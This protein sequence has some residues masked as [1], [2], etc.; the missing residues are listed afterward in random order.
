VFGGG[1]MRPFVHRLD[2]EFEQATLGRHSLPELHLDIEG[3]LRRLRRQ[4][5][6]LVG[7][8]VISILAGVAWLLLATPLYTADT[9]VLIDNR[10]IH[11][12]Q[13]SYD[14]QSQ[15]PELAGSLIDSQVEIVKSEKLAQLV[16]NRLNLLEDS[17]FNVPDRLGL[18]LS[19]RQT[20]ADLFSFGRAKKS[21]IAAA[22]GED[23]RLRRAVDLLRLNLDPRRVGRTMVLQISYTATDPQEAARIANAYA[24]A[25]LSDQL[26]AKYEATK[27]ASQWLEERM[28]ELKQKALAADIAIQKFKKDNDL[29]SSGGKL[30]NE[31]QL[32]EVNTQLVIA[33]AET[34]KAEARYSRISTIIK[35]H[36][37]DAIVPEAVGSAIV[38]QLRGKYLE[39]SKRESE[40]SATLGREHLQ[41]V[42]LRREMAEYERLMFEE[43]GR[44]SESARSE[45]DIAKEREQS[46]L[47]NLEKLVTLNAGENATLVQLH[48]MERE[49]EA[50]QRLHQSYLQRYQEALQQQSFPIIEARIITNAMPSA[51]PSSPKKALTLLMFALLG[52]L[53]GSGIGIVREMRERGLRGESEVKDELGLECLGILPL[54]KPAAVPLPRRKWESVDELIGLQTEDSPKDH[55]WLP[56]VPQLFSYV[57]DN[58]HSEFAETFLAIKLA[59]D[60]ALSDEATKVIGVVSCLPNEGKSVVSKNLASLIA[61][62]RLPAL[63]VDAD[64]RRREITQRLVPKATGGLVEAILQKRPLEDFLW[65]EKGSELAVLPSTAETRISHSSELLSSNGMTKLLDEA[66]ERFKYVILDLPPLG[67]IIDVRAMA[68]KIDAFVFVVEWRKTHRKLVRSILQTEER[69]AQKCLGVVLN[70]VEIGDIRMFEDTSSRH[71]FREQYQNYYRT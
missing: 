15:V 59:A 70:K 33:R 39:L 14:A 36:Q 29:I 50:Y 24:D 55:K 18:F 56:P 6:V 52:A 48:E 42:N 63:L 66:R 49:A 31:Q 17:K 64:I 45:L 57:L 12:V 19:L 47:K 7:A 20:L 58:P 37:T 3:F 54:V 43:L 9:L 35:G 44:L 60:L 69:V 10:R 34:G 71:Y 51:R 16:V 25:Y 26:N 8:G 41:A 46:L 2:R 5:T 61:T 22:S 30:V 23:I 53:A 68:E 21:S 65:W 62:L 4:R 13:D 40:I 67:P 28:H 32:A 1:F 11:A 38:G 27:R